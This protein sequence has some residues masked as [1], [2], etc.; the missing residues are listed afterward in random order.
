M[1]NNDLDLILRMRRLLHSCPEL[2]G[3]E[4]ATLNNIHNFL[5]EY[6][7]LKIE[8]NEGWLLARHTE[9][10]DLP[11]IA[12]RG[13]IDAIPGTDAPRHGCGHDG[14][15]AILCGLGLA[16]EGKKLGKN[17]YLIFQPAEETGCGAKM[18]CDSFPEIVNIRRIYGLHNIPGYKK[19]MLLLKNDCFACASCGMIVSVQGRPAHAA[20]P[21][22]GAN[23]AEALSRLVL[24]LPG[25]IDEILSG[26]NRLLMHTVVGLNLG[27]ENFGLSASEGKL[28]LTLR[29]H[30]Q[31]DINA[32][33]EKI[34][35]RT[36]E[37]CAGQNMLC[38]FELC[39][40]F[41]DTTNDIRS[42]GE[43][44]SIWSK[45]GMPMTDLCEPMRWSEDF[46]WYLKKIPG[47]FF[48]I[49]SGENAPGLHTENYEFN[50]ALIP[51]AVDAF[52]ALAEN[53]I[54]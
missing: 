21:A 45:T 15:S 50:D 12:F 14:H 53:I 24:E 36:R 7:T 17:I 2:S 10:E 49:G 35:A 28:C 47:M 41:P 18:I 42:V 25:T 29:G 22:D 23:P 20:Y 9:G 6:T 31:T 27:G 34:E 51:P 46:G 13:D 4:Q 33:I 3:Q 19:G 52:F 48:G 30:R 39:D 11:T 1:N 43:A 32:L 5:K 16:L 54:L 38:T 37:V 40:V 44:R 26:D 8:R